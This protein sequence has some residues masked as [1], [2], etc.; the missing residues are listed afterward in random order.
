MAKFSVRVRAAKNSVCPGKAKPI[1]CIRALWIGPGDYTLYFTPG[2][3]EGS[4][5][6]RR[7]GGSSTL[8]GRLPGFPGFT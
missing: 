1:S 5:F 2:C 8:R 3:E 4:L 6:Q 7:A